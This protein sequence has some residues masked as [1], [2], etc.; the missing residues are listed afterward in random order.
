LRILSSLILTLALAVAGTASATDARTSSDT[1]SDTP[2]GTAVGTDSSIGLG[3]LA[4]T[5]PATADAADQSLPQP[6]AADASATQQQPDSGVL[7]DIKLY[8]TA[9]LRWDAR[10]WAWFGGALLA[11][12]AAHHYDTQVRTHFI[13]EYP[14][15]HIFNSDDVQDLVPTVAVVGLTWGYSALA[16][17]SDGMRET[18]AMVEAAGLSTVTAYALKYIVAREG[19]NDT[20][21]SNQ[22]FKGGGD[23]FPSFHATVA[24][25]VGTVLAE[26]GNDEYRWL[27]RVLGYGLGVVTSYERL[28]HNAHWLSDTVAGAAIGGATANFTMHRRYGANEQSSLSVE[29]VEG[30]AML[31][32]RLNMP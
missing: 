10:N 30:G 18:G 4:L 32:Y 8:F 31:T 12:G 22:W 19:P 6:A 11:I 26:S 25:A 9:P 23:S 14:P 17:D 21:N 5:A 13:K 1:P 15:G 29:P 27:R 2:I 7:T 28:K 3:T 20:S 16:G 24:F